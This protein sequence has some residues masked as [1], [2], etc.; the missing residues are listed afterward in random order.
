MVDGFVPKRIYT[1]VWC[2]IIQ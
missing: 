2:S 1:S